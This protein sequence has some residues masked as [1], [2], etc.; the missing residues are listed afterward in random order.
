MIKNII[1][2]VLSLLFVISLAFGI[3]YENKYKDS[4]TKL[5]S[6]L[7]LLNDNKFRMAYESYILGEIEY[8]KRK[9]ISDKL[10]GR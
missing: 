4:Q 7:E 10:N 2:A 5:D 6:F 9:N 1:I 8:L 3:Y